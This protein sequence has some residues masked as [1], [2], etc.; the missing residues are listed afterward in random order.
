MDAVFESVQFFL[1][2]FLSFLLI[3]DT[4]TSNEILLFINEFEYLSGVLKNRGS[5]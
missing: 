5:V 4:D 1:K 2:S 3:F